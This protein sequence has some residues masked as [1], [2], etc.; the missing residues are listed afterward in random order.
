MM[1]SSMDEAVHQISR[2]GTAIKWLHLE[3]GTVAP[4]VSGELL[5]M[6]NSVFK[7]LA[8]TTAPNS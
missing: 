4:T 5:F 7:I 1:G 6:A 8:Q 2:D 3:H